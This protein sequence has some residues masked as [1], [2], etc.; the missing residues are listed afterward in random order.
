MNA[1][2]N[3][4]MNILAFLLENIFANILEEW[5]RGSLLGALRMH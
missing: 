4:L 1:K 5:A 2:I 3:A